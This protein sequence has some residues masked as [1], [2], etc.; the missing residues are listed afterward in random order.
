VVSNPYHLARWWPK[1]ARVE[2]VQ[3]RTRGTGTL[4]TKVLQTQ[5]GRQVRADFRCLY[6]KSPSAYGWEQEI[7]GSPFAKV[8]RSSEIGI[9]L[10]NS[11]GG[12]LVTLRALQRLR[13]LSRF[14]GFMLR[15]ATN[16]QLEEA[17]DGLERALTPAASEDE[18]G[19]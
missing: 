11:N 6:S 18:G 10:E 7:E 2:A 19:G 4:W 3:E 12:T 15:R 1:V 5:A 13:G 16:R 14:G 8:L 9:D 17:L